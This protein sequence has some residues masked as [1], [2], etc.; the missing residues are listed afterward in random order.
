MLVDANILLYS[1]DEDSQFHSRARD[2]LVAALNG[3]KRVGIPW[4]SLWAFVR[5]VTN[6]R[7][8]ALPLTPVEAWRYVEDWLDAPASWTPQPGRGHRSILQT[9]LARHDIRAGLVPDAVLAAICVEHGL[10]MISADSDFAR[11][12]EIVW[13][14]PVAAS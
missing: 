6:P 10:T 3:P 9:L 5:I 1:V 7:A 13:V 11:F 14:N 12:P 2:W 4:T 8:L